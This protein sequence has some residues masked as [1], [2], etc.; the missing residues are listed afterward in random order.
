MAD[1]MS[2][3]HREI[4]KRIARKVMEERGLLPDFPP[5]AMAELGKIVAAEEGGYAREKIEG[6]RD[7]RSLP[8]CSI[9]NPDSRD[10]DQLSVTEL[11]SSQVT[12]VLVAIADV[13]A[14]VA[15]DTSIDLRARH[16][17]STV[18][19][20]A[21]VFHMLP[22]KLSTD[23]SSLNLGADRVAI[24]I[25]MDV[26]AD[27]QVRTSNVYRA[28]VRNKARLNYEDVAHWLDGNGPE[29]D[30]IAGIEGLAENLR[31][32]DQA[33]TALRTK[34][35][36]YGA[37]EFLSREYRPIFKG[38][39]L[40]ELRMTGK[41]RAK[42]AIENFMIAANG[43]VAR[44]LEARRLPVFARV[45]RKPKRWD[46]I[47]ALAE[48]SG[49][50]LPADPDPK[51]LS[52]FLSERR[53]KDPEGFPDLS[54][55]VVKLLGPGE[56]VP[57]FPGMEAEGHFGLAVRDYAHSTAPNRRYPDLITHRLLKAAISGK[58]SPYGNDEL[59]ELGRRCSEGEDDVNKVERQVA[60]SAA[61][62]LLRSRIGEKFSALVTGASEKGTWIRLKN[63]PAEGRLSKGFEGADVGEAVEARL[64][65]VDVERGYIDF[66][67]IAR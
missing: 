3:S 8:W 15:K 42:D 4:L 14:L 12:R 26:S 67:R 55:S 16:N 46:R 48:K 54:L 11:T 39:A 50:A 57:R 28:I 44:F 40:A 60:K 17:T 33:A 36:K 30:G 34:R 53:A 13:D 49:H 43:V 20:A 64:I 52:A 7:K 65:S 2:L 31:G 59:V 51:A 6:L 27:G 32:Q 24:V 47:V 1:G 21:E 62:L 35:F 45:V 61:A 41:D 25:E 63:M 18:Y 19:T 29:P 37:L 23:L 5:E 22:E 9:D 66:E 38:D 56:Y 58:P 10:L